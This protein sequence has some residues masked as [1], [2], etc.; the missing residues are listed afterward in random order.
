MAGQVRWYILF[1]ILS[2]P[3]TLALSKLL[4][5]YWN[6]IFSTKGVT[7]L[8]E[9]IEVTVNVPEYFLHFQICWHS[10]LKVNKRIISL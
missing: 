9:N 6:N 7:F 10:T 8:Y 4:H 5:R 1:A 3:D 2:R